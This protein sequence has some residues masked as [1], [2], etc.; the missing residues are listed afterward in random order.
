MVTNYFFVSKKCNH[1]RI[2]VASSIA[3]I[4]SY[5]SGQIIPICPIYYI[6]DSIIIWKSL[7]IHFR[8]LTQILW[9]TSTLKKSKVLY[10]INYTQNRTFYYSI[11]EFVLI[12]H[13]KS[14]A[15]LFS[16][17]RPFNVI[18]IFLLIH[19]SSKKI[20]KLFQN[21]SLYNTETC[22]FVCD[23]ITTVEPQK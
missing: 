5:H 17:T 8:F 18:Y 16:I 21:V 3:A 23:K 2:R 4:P 15:F 10:I 14:I 19:K 1:S 6:L 20:K 12:F 13:S 22:L 11:N 7:C 9:K